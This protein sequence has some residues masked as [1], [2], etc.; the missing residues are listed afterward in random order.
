MN[1]NNISII[2]PVYNAEKY[3][4]E[5]LDSII[6]QKYESFEVI[7]IDDGSKDSS[8]SILNEYSENDKRIKTFHIENHGVSYARN[9][10]I[11]KATNDYII[12]VDSDDLLSPNSLEK[13]NHAI[14]TYPDFDLI[15][16]TYI[17]FYEDTPQSIDSSNEMYKLDNTELEKATKTL[18]SG[19]TRKDNI[20]IPGPTSKIYRRK[21]LID[22]NVKF[23]ESFF[24]YE[25]GIFNLDYLLKS[26]NVYKSKMVTYFYRKSNSSSLTHSFNEKFLTQ[27]YLMIDYIKNIIT[28]HKYDIKYYYIFCIESLLSIYMFYLFNPKR[29]K[30]YK[31]KKQEFNEII[32]HEGICDSL[33]LS[34]LKLVNPKKKIIMLL[35]IMK[36]YKLVEL[37]YKII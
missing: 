4:R 34:N 24:M 22:W 16:T 2:I 1:E 15:Q 21:N 5:T 10:G 13:I 35:T 17:E 14:N 37:I 29:P 27:R 31:N 30:E 12:F 23:N 32:K 9:L 8:L 20:I 11:E 3:I 36:F 28:E 19:I 33:K 18:L 6:N 25:D 7:L 26:K